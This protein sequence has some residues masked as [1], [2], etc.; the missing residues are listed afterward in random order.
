MLSSYAAELTGL[1]GAKCVVTGGLGFIGSNLV[2]A[3]VHAGASVHVVDALVP[4]HGGDPRNLD[5]VT[6]DELLIAP[7][8]DDGVAGLVERADVVFNVAGQVSHHASMTDPL[9][10]LELNVRSQVAFLET[11]RR[12]A[13]GCRI[14]LT[15]TRQV[16][17]RPVRLPV[18]EDH[19]TNPVDVNGIDKL[20]CEQY[21]LLYGTIHGLRP[22]VLRLTNVYGPRQN[23]SK[24]GLGALPVFLRR[25]LT[26]QPIQLFGT[27]EQLRDC[28]HVD[29]VVGA[30]VTATTDRS[31]GAIVNLG[32]EHSWSLREIVG[33]ILELSRSSSDLSYVP[34]PPDLERIDIGDFQGD[35]TRAAELLGW[36]PTIGL[37]DG[38]RSTID[39]YRKHPWYLS[40]T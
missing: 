9:T 15:S 38:L 13:P 34:W 20:A 10:D 30:I 31:V 17:G 14:V 25:A 5:G 40:S 29:D 26:D 23:L 37:V 28:L 36:K 19:P 3:L 24:D 18:D 7:L 16:Y 21:H 11:L 2:H 22:T 8:D 39:F 32:H 27:G 35:W 4:H 12:T 6:P 1:A 33:E